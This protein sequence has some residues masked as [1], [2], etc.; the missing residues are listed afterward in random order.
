MTQIGVIEI[1]AGTL[2]ILGSRVIRIICCLSLVSL[3]VGAL[4]LASPF[5][6]VLLA[7]FHTI[8]KAKQNSYNH[9]IY[10]FPNHYRPHH[11]NCHQNIISYH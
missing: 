1:F 6:Y 2:L 9:I 10:T 3:M 5:E 7:C 4:Y 8:Y 11:Y